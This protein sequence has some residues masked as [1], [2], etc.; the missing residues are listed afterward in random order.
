M[1]P[2]CSSNIQEIGLGCE[3]SENEASRGFS[4]QISLALFKG[5]AGQFEVF[6][7]LRFPLSHGK[8]AEMQ[9]IIINDL[10]RS[11]YKHAFNFRSLFLGLTAAKFEC[12]VL[13]FYCLHALQ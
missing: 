5:D 2:F 8:Q 4:S 11:L 1:Q 9:T 10:A 7:L 12:A 3:S 6:P 13:L